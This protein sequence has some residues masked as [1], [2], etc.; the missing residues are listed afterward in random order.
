[1]NQDPYFKYLLE[2]ISRAKDEVQKNSV[3]LNREV[4]MSELKENEVRRKIRTA[5]REERY[6]A[7]EDDDKKTF[8]IFRL[9]LDDLDAEL[10]PLFD[11][12]DRSDDYIREA[13]DEVAD[14]EKTLKWPS[15]VDAVK[16]EGLYVLRDLVAATR[17]GRLAGIIK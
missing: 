8:K 17:A 9:T 6:A 11:G 13:A 14:L 10:L 16:R 7:M 1:M 4:R 2:N 3:S 12:E 15:G 5:E